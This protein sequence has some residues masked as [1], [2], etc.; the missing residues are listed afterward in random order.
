M[1]SSQIMSWLQNFLTVLGISIAVI[2]I[3]ALIWIIIQIIATWRI[4]EKAG[5]GGWK[6][7]IPFYNEYTLFR[8]TFKQKYVAWIFLIGSLAS[9]VLTVMMWGNKDPGMM[10]TVK[11]ILVMVLGV[12]LLVRCFMLSKAFGHGFWFGL[13]IVF[14]E[15]IYRMILGFS[16]DEY[17]GDLHKKEVTAGTEMPTE[18]MPASTVPSAAQAPVSPAPE[19]LPTQDTSEQTAS[20]DSSNPSAQQ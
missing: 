14:M 9:T 4:F 3:I 6:S 1:D 18:T 13:G 5:E 17:V 16:H 12:M 8:I 10:K 11:D 19:S 20:S 15:R 2:L 7:I